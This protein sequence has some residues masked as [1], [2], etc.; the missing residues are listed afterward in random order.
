[1]RRR[2]DVQILRDFLKYQP[3]QRASVAKLKSGLKDAWNWDA[4]KVQR[5][6]DRAVQDESFAIDKGKGGVI[7]FTGAENME[8]SLLYQ[9]ACQVLEKS[10]ASKNSLKEAKAHVSARGGRKGLLDWMHPDVVVIGKPKRRTGPH[11]V[12]RHH[13]FEV[14]RLGGFHLDSIFQAFVQG[15]GS[16]YSWVLF[17]EADIRNDLYRER[18]FWAADR[19]DVGLISYGKPGSFSTWKMLRRA[20]PRNPTSRERDEFREYAMGN[21]EEWW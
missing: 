2:S 16:D 13:S 17:S 9:K 6:I 14:E 12:I 11:D 18:V 10:W 8:G 4:S 15:K 1:M 3:S 7:E 21:L 5:V 19:V 20:Q